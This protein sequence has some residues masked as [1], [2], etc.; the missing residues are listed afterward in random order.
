[1]NTLQKTLSALGGAAILA[2]GGVAVNDAMT[3]ALTKID[4]VAQKYEQSQIKE[5]YKLENS[6]FVIKGKDGKN[7]TRTAIGEGGSAEFVPSFEIKKWDGQARL[8]VNP[9]I[10]GVAKKDKQLEI[11]GDKIKYKAGKVGYVF[12]DIPAIITATTT[13]DDGKETLGNYSVW[14]TD[15]VGR[16]ATTTAPNEGGFEFEIVLGEIPASNVFV[17]PIESEG[18]SF[19][20]QKALNE[21]QQEEGI[22]C[23]AT[24]CRDADGRITTQRPIDIVD[25]IAVYSDGKSGDFTLMGGYNY[26]AGKVAHIKRIE[27]I[28][29]NGATEYCKQAIADNLWT[30]D[31]PM[32]WL[33]GAVYPVVVDPTFGYTTVGTT[34]IS[35]AGNSSGVGSLFTG[36]AGTA[37]LLTV[38]GASSSGGNW[39]ATSIY[40]HSDLTLIVRKNKSL[41]GDTVDGWKEV[42][43]VDTNI[44][45]QEYL[46]MVGTNSDLFL[47][48]YDTGNENQG[49]DTSSSIYL[50]TSPITIT[51]HNTKKYSIYATYTAGGGGE[52]RIIIT[53]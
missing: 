53:E 36:Y 40:K 20:P 5:K 13:D 9:D 39:I 1:M 33:S 42:D 37:T 24:E 38:H 50:S 41:Y 2:G 29:A 10:S 23:I 3:P 17:L 27:M 18:L 30:I 43:I 14:G 49:H 48:D 7:D 34:G 28:D 15:G 45:A 22:D 21:E 44:T 46:L 35:Y 8:K 19:H 47:V 52:R 26:M 32:A 12:Y 4:K 25:S 6:Q 51:A 16:Q 11:D 31:C